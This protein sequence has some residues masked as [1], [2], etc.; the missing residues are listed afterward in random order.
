VEV[1]DQLPEGVKT[2]D[3]DQTVSFTIEQLPAGESEEFQT[4]VVASQPGEYSSRAI[5]KA[6]GVEE[7]RSAEATTTVQAAQLDAS[8]EGPSA[9][10]VGRMLTYTVSV[11]NTGKVPAE[12]A[13]LHIKSPEGMQLRWKSDVS[14]SGANQEA[15]AANPPPQE[16]TPTPAAG[17][18]SKSAKEASAEEA[19]RVND[20]DLEAIVVVAEVAPVQANPG[21][22]DWQL[23]TLRPGESATAKVSFVGRKKG[24]VELQA[25]ANFDCA[26]DPKEAQA[27]A[28]AQTNLIALPAIAVAVADTPDPV[29]VGEDVRY[30]ITVVNEGN[31][32]DKQV[33]VT[34]TLPESLEYVDHA[35]VTKGTLEGQTL[36]FETV[37]TLKPG[38]EAAWTVRA[39]AKSAGNSRLTVNVSSEGQDQATAE[40]PT[41]LFDAS[42]AQ[43]SAAQENATPPESAEEKPAEEPTE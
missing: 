37:D 22:L 28:T 25:I 27:S 14:K 4:T 36:T 11:K 1:S 16:G 3:G 42:E 41:R 35:G 6:E 10:Y 39:K 15:Q 34:A 21:K 20:P 38:E 29:K 26:S 18:E 9:E 43:D 19:R 2:T 13:T 32:E 33:K 8:I 23:G 31:A 17:P 7:T 12:N 40:E 30:V 5:A 24:Q